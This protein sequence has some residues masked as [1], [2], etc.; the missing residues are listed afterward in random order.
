MSSCNQHQFS[1]NMLQLPSNQVTVSSNQ[2]LLLSNQTVLPSNNPNMIPVTTQQ[3]AQNK[4]IPA[5]QNKHQ[6]FVNLENF[7]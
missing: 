5:N 3:F 7:Q 1:N 6:K 4:N 2:T